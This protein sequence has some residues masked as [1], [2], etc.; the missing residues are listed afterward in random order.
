M[1]EES[2]FYQQFKKNQQ[3]SIVIKIFYKSRF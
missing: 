3:I 1:F 2:G